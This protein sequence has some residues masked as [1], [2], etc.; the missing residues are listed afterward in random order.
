MGINVTRKFH[1]SDTFHLTDCKRLSLI[2]CVNG[3]KK[4]IIIISAVYHRHA[5]D[6][7]RLDMICSWVMETFNL[8]TCLENRLLF[9]LAL[10]FLIAL[11][12]NL[13]L[14][15]PSTLAL[16]SD[17]ATVVFWH[18]AFHFHMPF[19]TL[20]VVESCFEQTI[21]YNHKFSSVLNKI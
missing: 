10:W 17:P 5:F 8:L 9:I 14:L 16:K 18:V 15:T 21:S 7:I 4:N 11:L 2:F 20:C 12:H 1:L 19:P 13:Q 3:S 6:C